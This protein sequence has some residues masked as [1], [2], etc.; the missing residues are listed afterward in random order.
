[1]TKIMRVGLLS[2][3]SLMILAVSGLNAQPDFTDPT[4]GLLIAFVSNRTGNSDIYVMDATGR[5]Q[6]NLSQSSADDEDP[7]WSPDGLR[8]AFTTGRDGNQEIYAVNYQTRTSE[9]LTQM[10]DSNETA[11]AWSPTNGDLLAFVSDSAAANTADI[12]LMSLSTGETTRLTTDTR[13]KKDLSWLPDGSALAYTTSRDGEGEQIV[14]LTVANKQTRLLTSIGNQ[15]TQVSIGASCMFFQTNRRDEHWQ[16][17]EMR[18]NGDIQE[19]I[20]SLPPN[21]GHPSISRD[22]EFLLYVSDNIDS[23]EIYLARATPKCGGGNGSADDL[24]RLTSNLVSDHSPVWQ[25]IVVVQDIPDISETGDEQD[26]AMQN[27][28]STGMNQSFNTDLL[29]RDAL[30]LDDLNARNGVDVWHAADW[31]G[32]G[33]KIAVL[34]TGFADLTD[35]INTV[36][37]GKSI[38]VQ[39]D[40][41]DYNDDLNDHGTKVIEIVYR[42]APEAQLF[43][44]RYLNLDEFDRCIDW[45][46]SNGVRIINHSAGL[47]LL[48]LDGTNRFS[49]S[50]QRAVQEGVLWINSAG[51]FAKGYVYYQNASDINADGFVDM[52]W[53]GTVLRIENQGFYE[54][55]IIISWLRTNMDDPTMP[56]DVQFELEVLNLNTLEPIGRE[57]ITE[58]TADSVYRRII[59]STE[60]SFGLRVRPSVPLTP[61]Q[62]F[63]FRIVLFV[64]FLELG[65]GVQE[66]SVLAPGDAE[67]VI[68]VGAVTGR[69]NEIAPF[70]SVGLLDNPRIKPDLATYGSVS[71]N[72][73]R[74]SSLVDANLIGTSAAAPI[75]A[76]AAALVWEANPDFSW[77]EIYN[78]MRNDALIQTNV[79][80]QAVGRGILQLPEPPLKVVGTAVLEIDPFI[81]FVTPTPSPLSI[82]AECPGAITPRLEVGVRGFILKNLDILGGLRLR[83]EPSTA[84]QGTILAQ[85]PANTQFTVI[86]GP[87][88]NENVYW[89]RV[90]LDD[91][92]TGWMLEGAY[93]VVLHNDGGYLLAPVNLERAQ[94]LNMDDTDICTSPPTQLAIG[95]VGVM[96][97]GNMTVYQEIEQRREYRYALERGVRVAILGGPRCEGTADRIMRWY[98]RALDGPQQG[99]EGWVAES[100]PA[101]R[102]IQLDSSSALP[103]ST[104][105]PQQAT[106]TSVIAAMT[107]GAPLP[108]AVPTADG[109]VEVN[110][111]TLRCN[112]R[113]TQRVNTRTGPGT[114]FEVARAQ[115]QGTRIRAVGYA[116]DSSNMRWWRLLDRTWVREDTVNTPANQNCDALALTSVNEALPILNATFPSDRG[117]IPTGARQLG[118]GTGLTTGRRLDNGEMELEGY[119]SQFGYFL[120]V[121]PSSFVCQNGEQRTIF[122][123]ETTDYDVA[124]QQTY[125]NSSAFALTSGPKQWYC[126]G[127]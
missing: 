67:N 92:T 7:T 42:V 100:M 79:N 85:L 43:A 90:E 93:D 23:D 107:I 48:P 88:C 114:T 77:D 105:G 19:P 49:Q 47:P 84:S 22:G 97:K 4:G 14:L 116:L 24:A 20:I 89:W 56:P 61:N 62:L 127:N 50:A 91:G 35:L 86:E 26:T 104:P 59:V 45:A 69:G 76:G 10:P 15:N 57:V 8:V 34:D 32:S 13:P 52:G 78:Y 38:S 63:T 115:D 125:E 28:F 111:E 44:C 109:A 58:S 54:G 82:A 9:N 68:T 27:V 95:T 80:S 73:D 71:L 51:N 119:C 41:V 103:T 46:L 53:D 106:P 1:M 64:E 101:D 112:I 55:N 75:V 60:G 25:P 96:V 122:T 21:S 72:P 121:T 110:T 99:M 118:G 126:Y 3:I 70:S 74:F 65:G 11:P 40:P 5:N 2:I 30:S 108:T 18:Q 117:Q 83:S 66:G 98:V 120:Q 87:R 113:F 39:G 17:F 12:Y 29:L 16:V 36:M 94:Y 123:L 6:R 102:F 124:C 31:R 33:Q 37:E 81:I